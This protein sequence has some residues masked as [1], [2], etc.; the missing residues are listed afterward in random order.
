MLL[1]E[2]PVELIEGVQMYTPA[3]VDLEP[4]FDQETAQERRALLEEEKPFLSYFEL[5]KISGYS[6]VTV[7][8]D[9]IDIDVHAGSS[10]R[11]WRRLRVD[12]SSLG[13]TNACRPAK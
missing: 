1:S 13:I 9:A 2:Q 3:L 11:T 8:K 12:R 4:E 6:V 5:A 7:S 10:Q